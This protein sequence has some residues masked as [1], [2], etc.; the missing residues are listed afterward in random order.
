MNEEQGGPS[1]EERLRSAREKQGLDPLPPKPGGADDGGQSPLGI[2]FRVAVEL[3]SALLVACAI[4]W[5]IDRLA[6]T[7]PWFLIAFVPLGG[8]AGILNVWRSFAP[9]RDGG[10]NGD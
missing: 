6:G 2:G 1:F 10:G 5:G 3:L 7:R 9:R 8:A 4:G